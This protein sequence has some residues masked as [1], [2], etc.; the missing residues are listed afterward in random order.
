MHA[1][2][3]EMYGV[4]AC[5]TGSDSLTVTVINGVTKI[6]CSALSAAAAVIPQHIV[7]IMLVACT[8]VSE[9]LDTGASGCQVHIKNRVVI[10]AHAGSTVS[11]SFKMR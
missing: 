8:T 6:S 7:R 2:T 3:Y 1:L 9:A 4:D 5:C 11:Q 10:H